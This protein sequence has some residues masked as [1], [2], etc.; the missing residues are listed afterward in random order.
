MLKIRLAFEIIGKK[1]KHTSRL[2]PAD[3]DVAD[4]IVSNLLVTTS[5][6]NNTMKTRY[7][8]IF[9][10]FILAAE[11]ALRETAVRLSLPPS[12][13]KKSHA[14]ANS[15]IFIYSSHTLS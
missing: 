8:Y 10:P 15:C 12:L 14:H 11:L 2:D 7:H 5:K 9:K 4:F 13:P 3:D 6:H 1:I